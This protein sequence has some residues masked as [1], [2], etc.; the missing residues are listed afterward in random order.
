M[1]E[2]S[3]YRDGHREIVFGYVAEAMNRGWSQTITP[4]SELYGKINAFVDGV[5]LQK[6]YLPLW[7]GKDIATCNAP[8]KEYHRESPLVK[9]ISKPFEVQNS[10]GGEY[11]RRCFRALLNMILGWIEAEAKAPTT[12]L[13][14]EILQLSAKAFG[15]PPATLGVAAGSAA[16]SYTHL[17]LP[18]NRE[19]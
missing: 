5:F 11:A 7:E 19:V 10:E 2:G 16:V 4:Q 8:P 12:G 17:T 13:E 6:V 15:A 9:A 18:T 1:S 14:A 3:A